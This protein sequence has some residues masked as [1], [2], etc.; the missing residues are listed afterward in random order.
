MALIS[1]RRSSQ[2]GASFVLAPERYDPRR[3]MNGGAN[4]V[5][6]S[7]IVHHV[8]ETVGVDAGQEN[9][10]ILDT[11][12]VHEGIVVGRKKHSSSIGSTKKA[13]KPGDVVISRLRPYLRQAA[14]VDDAIWNLQGAALVCS[15][16]FFVMRS[17]DAKSIAFLV[18]FLLSDQVQAVLRVS[19]EGGH[20][21]RFDQ[22]VLFSLPVPKSWLAKRDKISRSLEK[23]IHLYRQSEH[24][25]FNLV[26]E[27]N[28]E[29]D[30]S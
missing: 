8:R 5:V 6:L 11:S 19:Q 24:S 27:A 15:T 4:A 23:A 26:A 28:Q 30:H 22:E 17:V 21:P 10:L 12:D 7:E 14:F 9:Y 13:L 25:I 16:E 1:I 18:P 29:L 3:S 20:H 2:L